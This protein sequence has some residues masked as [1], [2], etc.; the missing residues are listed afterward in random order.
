[1]TQGILATRDWPDLATGQPG[2]ANPLL[3]GAALIARARDFMAHWPDAPAHT[4]P[5]TAAVVIEWFRGAFKCGSVPDEAGVQSLVHWLNVAGPW[6]SDN[7]KRLTT[8]PPEYKKLSKAIAAV[9]EVAPCYIEISETRSQTKTGDQYHDDMNREWH[10]RRA[11]TLRAVL[12][13]ARATAV[14]FPVLSSGGKKRPPFWKTTAQSAASF[15]AAALLQT[16]HQSPNFNGGPALEV[17]QRAMSHLE[18]KER[19]LSQLR[20]AFRL[21]K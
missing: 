2:T 6:D 19:P 11:R 10:D 9:L 12:I 14:L 5:V 8:L 4:N 18:G 3:E 16:G 1:M 17:L 7:V 20:E 21:R 15:I 13:G